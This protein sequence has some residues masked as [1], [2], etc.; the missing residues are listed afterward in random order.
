LVLFKKV[1]G[2]SFKYYAAL[3]VVWTVLAVVLDYLFLVLVLKPAGG[4]YKL[5]VYLYYALTIA[6]PIVVGWSK[7][8]PPKPGRS[9][10]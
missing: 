5:D 3:A 8:R 9:D 1:H 2:D 6:L 10:T 7:T 4:Y